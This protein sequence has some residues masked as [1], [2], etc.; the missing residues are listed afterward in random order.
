MTIAKTKELPAKV[1][2]QL[3]TDLTLLGLHFMAEH[4]SDLA[5]RAVR[6]SLGHI[7]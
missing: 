6:D 1:P 7:D 5:N 4:H 2:S 3:D